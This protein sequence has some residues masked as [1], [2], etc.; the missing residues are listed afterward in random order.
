MLSLSPPDPAAIAHDWLRAFVPLVEYVDVAGVLSLL[1]EGSFWRDRLALTRDMHTFHGPRK[2]K[3]VL[4]DRLKAMKLTNSRL[5]NP[6]LV[7]NSP[8]AVWIRSV[9]D[10]DITEY[11]IGA[12]VARL[13]LT[14]TGEWKGSMIY[15]SLSGLRDYPERLGEHR[16]QLPDHARRLER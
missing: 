9:F 5:C 12:A 10:F 13:V 4:D 1:T 7:D 16:S 11:G 2:I 15:T 8:V 3:W 6:S 14:P